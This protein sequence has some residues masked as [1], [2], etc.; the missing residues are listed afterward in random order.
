VIVPVAC[1]QGLRNRF[2]WELEPGSFLADFSVEWCKW[3]TSLALKAVGKFMRLA[4][5][6]PSGADQTRHGS[7]AAHGGRNVLNSLALT[8][9]DPTFRFASAVERTAGKLQ[10]IIKE[11]AEIHILLTHS[12]FGDGILRRLLQH[13][14][15]AKSTSVPLRFRWLRKM[16]LQ[17]GLRWHR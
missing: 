13:V 7:R 14:S 15:L 17:F 5:R 1:G 10:E 9:S 4:A 6:N 16:K 2:R 12:L 11:V 8:R 3:E